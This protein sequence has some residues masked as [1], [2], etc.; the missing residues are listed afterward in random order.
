MTPSLRSDPATSELPSSVPSS[1]T[2]PM[3][4]RVARGAHQAVDRVAGTASGA[5]E[6]MRSGLSSAG[7]TMSE[8]MDALSS[9][10]TQWLDNCRQ[11]VR[12]HPLAAIGIGLAA[13]WLV[14][15]LMG[16]SSSAE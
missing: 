13:G 7:S 14:A 1:M 12:E 6:R 8:Q 10:R 2:G 15:R 11:S 3:V 5:V 9:T 16:S 4:E